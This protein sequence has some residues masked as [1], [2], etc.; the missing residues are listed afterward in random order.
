MRTINIHLESIKPHFH[1]ALAYFSTWAYTAFDTV[2]IYEGGYDGDI[3][4]YFASSKDSS[5]YTIGAIWD[6]RTQKFSY[7]S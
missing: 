4:A 6:E 7:H 5:S 2:D 1:L 3:V